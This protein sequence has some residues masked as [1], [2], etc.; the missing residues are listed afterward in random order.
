MKKIGI[1]IRD[2]NNNEIYPNPFP[3]GAVYLSVD[4]RNPSQIFGGKWEQVKG[5]FLL[6]ADTSYK[7]KNTGGNSSH[8]HSTGNHTLTINEIPAHNHPIKAGYGDMDNLAPD[9]YRYQYWG[10]YDNGW[11]YGDLGTGNT[12]G[13]QAHNHGNT[14]SSS[15]MPPYFVVYIW[16]RVA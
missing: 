3:I 14:G 2:E 10:H 11:K 5:R 9:S 7:V 8:N 16:Y 15:N 1:Q 6:G 12:G 4:S 13:N